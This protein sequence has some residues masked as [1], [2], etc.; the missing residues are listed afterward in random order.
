MKLQYCVLFFLITGLFSLSVQS[1]NELNEDTNDLFSNVS[2]IRGLVKPTTT[3]VISSEISAQIEALNF[4]AG[5][6]F[7][8]GDVLVEFDCAYY[9]AELA[10]A[11]ADAEYNKMQLENQQQLFKLNANSKIEVDLAAVDLKKARANVNVRNITVSRCKIKA[12][13]NG[14][15][16]ESQVNQYESVAKDQELLSILNDEMLEIEVIVPS[17]WLNW[18][19][20]SIIFDFL[21]DET[22]V[23]YPAEVVQLGAVVDPVSQTIPIKGVFKNKVNVLSGM[24]GSAIFQIPEN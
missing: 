13:Y 24:S 6:R 18:L 2:T 10:A 14:R 17:N 9:L 21:V 15:V 16:I 23:A 1:E 12:P 20:P 8:K 11:R 4:K 19:K 7:K 5:E 3:A 22:G